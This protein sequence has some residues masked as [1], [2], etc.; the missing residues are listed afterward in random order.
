MAEFNTVIKGGT[1]IDGLRTP[2]YVADIGI[3]DGHIAYIGR[4]NA[5]DGDQVLDAAGLIVAPGLV[6]PDLT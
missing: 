6:R 2:R 5:S 3:T 1:I 4:L